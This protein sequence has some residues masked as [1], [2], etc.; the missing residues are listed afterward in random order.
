MSSFHTE[1]EPGS[2]LADARPR[3][4]QKQEVSEEQQQH[5]MSIADEEFLNTASCLF[6]SIV[7][8]EYSTLLQL[9]AHNARNAIVSYLTMK[10]HHAM[11]GGG[12][13]IGGLGAPGAMFGAAT[14]TAAGLSASLKDAYKSGAFR[15]ILHCQE[16]LRSQFSSLLFRFG[17]CVQLTNI[18]F[19]F[20]VFENMIPNQNDYR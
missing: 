7:K 5:P 1:L 17:V 13:G 3:Q 11:G 20:F 4:Q 9:Y 14:G 15:H 12:S 16:I 2:T 8:K 18:S 19:S 6:Q 10:H